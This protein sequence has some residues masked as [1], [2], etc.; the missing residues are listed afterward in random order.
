MQLLIFNLKLVTF[1][2]IFLLL[3][4]KTSGGWGV[5]FEVLYG[6]FYLVIFCLSLILSLVVL[7]KNRNLKL[8]KKLKIKIPK[9]LLLFILGLSTFLIIFNDGSCGSSHYDSNKISVVDE[10]GNFIQRII[11]QESCTP[12]TKNWVSSEYLFYGL[13]LNFILILV[14]VIISLGK[15]KPELTN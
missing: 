8:N 5:V 15:T 14:L 13:I 2:L 9:N 11:T 3:R 6:Y 4:I 10:T 7:V 12:T 1:L